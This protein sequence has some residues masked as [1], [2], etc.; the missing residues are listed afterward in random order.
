M[1]SWFNVLPYG[2]NAMS[3]Q[4]PVAQHL[5]PSNSGG[6]E[7]ENQGLKP[8]QANKLLKPY[9]KNIQHKKG[10]AEWLK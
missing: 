8:A 10:L 2:K 9:L 1:I 3:S 6:R 4:V 5:S 7:R